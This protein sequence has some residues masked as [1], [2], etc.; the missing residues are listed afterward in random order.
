[1][2]SLLY[3]QK[4]PDIPTNFF[5]EISYETNLFTSLYK[6]TEDTYTRQAL[7][8]ELTNIVVQNMKKKNAKFN[9]SQVILY[10][11]SIFVLSWNYWAKYFTIIAI[12][13]QESSK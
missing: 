4:L 11:E 9:I 2:Q 13:F 5:Y 10:T 6:S 1:M 3:L 8:K 7:K 12:N